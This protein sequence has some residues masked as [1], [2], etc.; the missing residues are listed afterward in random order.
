MKSGSAPGPSLTSRAPLSI[1]KWAGPLVEDEVHA[2]A[3]RERPRRLARDGGG[4]EEAPSA[5]SKLGSHRADVSGIGARGS[6]RGASARKPRLTAAPTRADR[7]P[8]MTRPVSRS[9]S[10]AL[11]R[12]R[13]RRGCAAHHI[14]RDGHRD[15]PDNRAVS[16]WS[17]AYRQ[18]IE[19]PRRARRPRAGRARLLRHRRHARPRRRPR[20]RAARSRP[21]RRTSPGLGALRLDCR[22]PRRRA[23]RARP[24]AAEIFYDGVLPGADRRAAPVPRRDSDVAPHP[25]AA[26]RRP[27]VD[28]LGL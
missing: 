27:L 26:R 24:R 5:A 18:A 21:S 20:P 11:R 16:T 8:A 14:A 4:L 15:T 25:A 10:L 13:L 9:S 1:V 22:D 19:K 12:R 28:R 2:R 23:S 7:V 3:A 6:R 17:R